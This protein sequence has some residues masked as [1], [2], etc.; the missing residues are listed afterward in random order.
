MDKNEINDIPQS[1]YI[2]NIDDMIYTTNVM[3]YRTLIDEYKDK[4]NVN[5]MYTDN[6]MKES[7]IIKELNH[8]IE[9]FIVTEEYERCAKLK[10]ILD[11]YTQH[12]FPQKTYK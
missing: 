3:V 8:L 2:D 11:E 4:G 7:N 1:G 6:N 10:K 12:G 9:A 5:S